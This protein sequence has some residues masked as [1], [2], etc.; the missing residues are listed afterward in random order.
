MERR[1]AGKL[2]EDDFVVEVLN[3][4]DEEADHASLYCT[5]NANDEMDIVDLG[6]FDAND[7][8]KKAKLKRRSNLTE[9]TD[10]QTTKRKNESAKRELSS[11]V[12]QVN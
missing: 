1:T 5:L 4:L 2:S 9:F 6:N 8:I 7:G 3:Q 10:A 12:K 11:I